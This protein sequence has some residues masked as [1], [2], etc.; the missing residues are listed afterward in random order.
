[1]LCCEGVPTH[2]CNAY[3]AGLAPRYQTREELA[4]PLVAC[5]WSLWECGGGIVAEGRLL[6]LI[7]RLYCFGCSLMTM[8]LRQESMRHTTTLNA[9]TRQAHCTWQGLCVGRIVAKR[10]GCRGSAAMLA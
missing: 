5:Y 3:L 6:D 10:T 4:A 9:V 8:D 1:M 2:P 7:R